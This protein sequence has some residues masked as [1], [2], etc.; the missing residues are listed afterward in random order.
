M[1]RGVQIQ[2]DAAAVSEHPEADRVLA[3]KKLL[4]WIDTN[5]EVVKEQV[6]VGAIGP[7]RTPQDV[8]PRRPARAKPGR[9]YYQHHQQRC[10]VPATARNVPDVV[11][12]N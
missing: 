10:S 5:I 3:L 6:V 4:L 2:L 11:A 1:Q 12:L 8:A 7:I 9:G